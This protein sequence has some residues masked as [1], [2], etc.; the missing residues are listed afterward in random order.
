VKTRPSPM[1]FVDDE[2]VRVRVRGRLE[3]FRLRIWQHSARPAVVLATAAGPGGIPPSTASAALANMAYRQYLAYAR[4]GM[5]YVELEG[6][7]LYAVGFTRIGHGDRV[8][9]CY[10]QRTEILARDLRSML[11]ED[12][13]V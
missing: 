11:G 7:R 1:R 10:P 4:S 2:V 13:D 3:P 12:R 9:L 8:R 6:G 5:L